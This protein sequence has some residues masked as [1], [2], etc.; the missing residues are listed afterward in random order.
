LNPQLTFVFFKLL[1][2]SVNENKMNESFIQEKLRK[3][4]ISLKSS[5]LM[6]ELV[7]VF[8]VIL[9]LYFH[10]FPGN[11]SYFLLVI[12]L[13]LL[14]CIYYFFSLGIPYIEN[15]TLIERFVWKITH[16]SYSIICIGFIFKLQLFPGGLIFLGIG[17]LSIIGS[18]IG[19]IYCNLHRQEVGI[20]DQ[21]MILRTIIFTFIEFI[22]LLAQQLLIIPQLAN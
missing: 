16:Y 22:L 8:F 21:S 5:L 1:Q 11:Q 17:A 9:G 3:V 13:S 20:F 10:A 2:I 18:L 19:M 6:I 15:I 12:P 7:I 4:A 14:A